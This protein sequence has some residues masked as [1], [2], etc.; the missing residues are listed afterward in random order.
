MIE[1]LRKITP[2]MSNHG[3]KYNATLGANSLTLEYGIE[4]ITAAGL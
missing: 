3:K 1:Y 2:R 4:S